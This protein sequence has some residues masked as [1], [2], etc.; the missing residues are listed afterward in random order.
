MEK[1]ERFGGL[2]LEPLQILGVEGFGDSAVSIRVMFTTQPLQQWTVGREFRRRIKNTFDERGIEIP[3]P[4]RTV[5]LGD[6]SPMDGRLRVEIA[7]DGVSPGESER[8]EGPVDDL[9][10]EDE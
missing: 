10:R 6:G 3:F 8:P 7:K 2:I 1:D 9:A 4:H 5:Y